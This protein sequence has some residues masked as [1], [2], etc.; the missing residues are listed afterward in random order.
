MVWIKKSYV[1]II[2]II[3]MIVLLNVFLAIYLRI[4]NQ[5]KRYYYELFVN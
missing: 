3:N 2:I 5:Y 1:M 4:N